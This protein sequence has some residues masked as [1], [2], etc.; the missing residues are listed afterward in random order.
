ML[1]L[2]ERPSVLASSHATFSYAPS[3]IW[4]CRAGY[5]QAVLKMLQLGKDVN[6][7]HEKG[8]TP[9]QIA[10]YYGQDQVVEALLQV[11]GIDV[12]RRDGEG[13]TALHNAAFCGNAGSLCMLLDA[14]ISVNACT[15]NCATPLHLACRHP[16]IVRELL[17]Q[18]ADTTLRHNLR[19]TPLDVARIKSYE[20]T[21]A[22]LEGH[23]K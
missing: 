3:L 11:Q 7:G 22:I 5:T 1:A 21:V 16:H 10:A 20:E 19:Y 14:G 15:H 9:L 18:G 6:E 8:T 17:R 12:G 13:Y 2:L 4:A 23:S